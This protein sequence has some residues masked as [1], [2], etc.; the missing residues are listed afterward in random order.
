MAEKL[1]C[2]LYRSSWPVYLILT[3]MPRRDLITTGPYALV[4]HPLYTGVALLVL[5]C[6][7]FLCNSWL[8][9]LNTEH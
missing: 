6:V 7:G 4:Q 3:K 8:G 1:A 9:A 2:L 5:P